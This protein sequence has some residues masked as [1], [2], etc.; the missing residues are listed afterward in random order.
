MPYVDDCVFCKILQK[1]IPSVSVYE[2]DLVLAFLD[3]APF[4]FGHALIVPKDHHHSCTTLGDDYLARMMQVAP[5]IA[6]AIMRATEAEGFN[7]FLNNG[8][9]AGQVVPHVHL[10]ILPRFANDGVL[11]TASTRK[12]DSTQAMT[13]LAEKIK[14]RITHV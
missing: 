4:N 10:H 11:M 8:S 1:Q 14:Q 12:Y 13:D 7:L 6:A 2:D 9:V 5:R 3:I